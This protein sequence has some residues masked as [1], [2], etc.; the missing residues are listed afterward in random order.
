MLTGQFVRSTIH[1]IRLLQ[2]IQYYSVTRI[3]VTTDNVFAYFCLAIDP[4]SV[5][6]LRQDKQ[7]YNG[8][9]IMT[10]TK[11]CEYINSGHT[12]ARRAVT[13]HIQTGN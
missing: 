4:I 6:G 9:W 7:S 11:V 8:Y 12:F 1:T 5:L 10:E 3:C 2:I 13:T